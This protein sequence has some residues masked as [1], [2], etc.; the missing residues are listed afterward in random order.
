MVRGSPPRSGRLVR[1]AALIA[2]VAALA[3]SLYAPAAAAQAAG[4][5][6]APAAK[7]ADPFG[8][9]SY[10]FVPAD[11]PPAVAEAIAALP[12]R[13]GLPSKVE[14]V[15]TTPIPGLFEVFAGGRIIYSTAD[16]AWVVDGS[17]VEASQLVNY[18]MHRIGELTGG[19]IDFKALPLQ[20]AIKTV[21]GDGRRTLVTFED[22]A[23]IFCQRF[24][25]EKRKLAD[26][27]IYTFQLSLQNSRERNRSIWCAADRSAAWFD[28]VEGKALPA[29][30][31]DCDTSHLARN[32]A[33]AR[34]LYVN[35]TPIIF[36]SD[37]TRI[38]GYAD[39]EKLM[40]ALR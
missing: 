28:S 10:S 24:A 34:R 4:L 32:E 20:D 33:L 16:G 27:T 26:V 1:G 40:S 2:A 23:C 7:P 3:A 38:R 30:P 13:L 35:G 15:R 22:P 19:P 25:N 36:L 8:P 12:G 29:A 17:M 5:R 31:A 9:R 37:G 6:P 18:T 39:A 11:A 21:L 14:A